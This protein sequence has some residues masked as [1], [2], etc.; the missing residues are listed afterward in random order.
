MGSRTRGFADCLESIKPVSVMLTIL[1]NYCW[2]EKMRMEN[3]TYENSHV[4][5]PFVK[6]NDYWTPEF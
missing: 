6:L 4:W 5:Q 3:V 1:K 2:Q